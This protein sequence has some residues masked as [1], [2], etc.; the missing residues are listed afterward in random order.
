MR[1]VSDKDG[2]VVYNWSGDLP[3]SFVIADAEYN[4]C[5]TTADNAQLEFN[6]NPINLIWGDSPIDENGTLIPLSSI[7]VIKGTKIRSH[8]I[9]LIKDGGE[10]KVKSVQAYYV[11]T[12]NKAQEPQ[13]YC[14]SCSFITGEN[15]YEWEGDL[16]DS[17]KIYATDYLNDGTTVYGH[18]S[19]IADKYSRYIDYSKT[20]MAKYSSYDIGATVFDQLEQIKLKID[21]IDDLSAMMTTSHAKK[22]Y[23]YCL[24][25][26]DGKIVSMA[27][28][29]EESW[30]KVGNVA[31]GD[32]RFVVGTFDKDTDIETLEISGLTGYFTNRGGLPYFQPEVMDYIEITSPLNISDIE[33]M[34]MAEVPPTTDGD[35]NPATTRFMFNVNDNTLSVSGPTNC[36]RYVLYFYND[37]DFEN[38]YIRIENTEGKLYTAPGGSSMNQREQTMYEKSDKFWRF[39]LWI[40]TEDATVKEPKSIRKQV[41]Y[42]APDYGDEELSDKVVITPETQNRVG[43]SS[44]L[45]VTFTNGSNEAENPQFKNISLLSGGV[46]GLN[47]DYS[48]VSKRSVIYVIDSK[49]NKELTALYQSTDGSFLFSGKFRLPITDDDKSF[50]FYLSTGYDVNNETPSGTFYGAAATAN[51]VIIDMA[52][53]NKDRNYNFNGLLMEN[54]T[55]PWVIDTDKIKNPY[56][57]ANSDLAIRVELSPDGT[58]RLSF[59]YTEKDLETGVEAFGLDS[60]PEMWFNLQGVRVASPERGIYIR[61][62]DGKAST[63]LITD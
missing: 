14:M 21:Q 52:L 57:P 46:Y 2:T 8:T 22:Q 56:Y 33:F 20:Y 10:W 37:S 39:D 36:E 55:R 63:V 51:A 45:N 34:N 17:F 27:D 6:S 16:F 11:G 29:D 62:R 3:S 54:S 50:G 26:N 28:D 60:L 61:V 25:F 40:P 35:G 23:N 44:N 31:V 5:L 4:I 13:R 32:R 12:L 53:S 18:F 43:K 41:I 1:I 7:Q 24:L 9:V 38:P 59:G 30:K 47:S 19:N 15:V 58:K 49:T 42:S 48:D